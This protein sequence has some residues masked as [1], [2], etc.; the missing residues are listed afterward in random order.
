MSQIEIRY[1]TIDGEKKSENFSI[2]STEIRLQNNGIQ[3]IDLT[4]LSACSDLLGI[5][6][7]DNPLKEVDVSPLFTCTN[8]GTIELDEET[9]P[10]AMNHL[11]DLTVHSAGISEILNRIE[12][13]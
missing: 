6:L 10:K 12:W 7:N 3:E 13:Y 11:A 8:L 4:P 9:V 5:W 1:V 2:D